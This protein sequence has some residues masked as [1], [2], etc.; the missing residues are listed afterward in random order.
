MTNTVGV[1]LEGSFAAYEIAST[2]DGTYKATLLNTE[3][4]GV[5]HYPEIIILSRSNGAWVSDHHEKQIGLLIGHKID[6][7]EKAG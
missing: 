4:H 6:E 5:T 7:Q 3:Y 1:Q 2:T